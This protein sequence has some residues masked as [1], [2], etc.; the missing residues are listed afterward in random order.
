[1]EI[2][3]QGSGKR[4]QLVPDRRRCR[5]SSNSNILFD[6]PTQKIYL[7]KKKIRD[8]KEDDP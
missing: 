5:F 7:L 6:T 2:K 1:M 4:V 8:L 3:P